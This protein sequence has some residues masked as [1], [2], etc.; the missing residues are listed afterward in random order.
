MP[1]SPL[2]RV[3]KVIRIRSS[4]LLVTHVDPDGDGIGSCL[5]LWHALRNGGK[6]ACVWLPRGIPEKYAFLPGSSEIVTTTAPLEVAIAL[7]CD[8][9]NRLGPTRTAVRQAEVVV[10]IDHHTGHRAFGDLTW[11]DP[12]APA[13][14]YQIFQLLEAFGAPC[15]PEIAS[16]LY[17]AIGTDSGF[18]RYSN[19][20]A[21]LLRVAAHL[22]ECGANP[23]AI[24][25]ATL[26]R[27]QPPL[28][29]LAGKALASVRTELGG[30]AAVA[31]LT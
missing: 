14:G 24:A 23:K 18:F 3:G 16:C 26:D 2:E 30:R 20:T 17:C 21:N 7:D 10:D 11:A 4:F 29:R 19:T 15:T 6:T 12:S 31:V 5:A 9:E 8:G 13:T 28:V 22:I 27:Y 25:E 1:I